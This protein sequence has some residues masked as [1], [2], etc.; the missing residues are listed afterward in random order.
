MARNKKAKDLLY[1]LGGPSPSKAVDDPRKLEVETGR[2]GGTL[3]SIDDRIQTADQ[4]FAKSGLDP[5][6]W[7]YDSAKVG[8]Y[9]VAMKLK[10]DGRHVV[11]IVKLWRIELQLRRRISQSFVHATDALI[12]RMKRY[13]PVF[14]RIPRIGRVTDPHLVEISIFDTHFGK[15]AHA[16]ETGQNYDLK[17]A[18]NL[19]RNAVEE[20]VAKASGFPIERFLFPIGNDFFH[21]DNLESKTTAGTPQDADGRYW[22]IYDTGVQAVIEAIEYLVQIAPVD[23][24]W[25]PGNHDAVASGH[26]ARSVGTF[27]RHCRSVT[28][29]TSPKERKY[30]AYGGMV[31][32]FTH[33]NEEKPADLVPIMQ[34]EARV[35]LADRSLEIHLGH[36]HKAKEVIHTNADTFAGGVRVRTLPSLSGTDKWHYRK[37]YGG[38]RAAE[39]YVWSKNSGFSALLSA[40]VHN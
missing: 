34:S 11:E 37:G 2:S 21:I 36:F 35:M 28:V 18:A 19:Y 27:F 6:I 17:I 16:A 31:L 10:S 15:L 9:E 38:P 14:P 7:Y 1:D 40:N 29:D 5:D 33:G 8:S 25:V 4:A 24:L 13:S 3:L 12:E 26:M 32:G 30:Y 20:L 23:L 22:K 39:A